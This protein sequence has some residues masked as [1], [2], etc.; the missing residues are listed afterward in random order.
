[1]YVGKSSI[2]YKEII[3]H[4]F[5]SGYFVLKEYVKDGGMFQVLQVHVYLGENR[6]GGGSHG[7]TVVPHLSLYV[8]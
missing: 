5:I 1:M 8:L 3:V 4:I 7:Q 6:W 2:V